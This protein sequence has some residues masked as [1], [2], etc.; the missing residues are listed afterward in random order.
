MDPVLILIIGVVVLLVLILVLRLNAFI[1]LITAA[2]LV[3][4]LS[5]GDFSEKIARVAGAFGSVVGGIGIVIALAA[6]I[7]K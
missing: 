3:S 4:L 5:P 2:M 1:A 6:V 7:G